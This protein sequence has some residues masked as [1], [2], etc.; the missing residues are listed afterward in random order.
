MATYSWDAVG[1]R[2]VQYF[3]RVLGL[4]ADGSASRIDDRVQADEPSSLLRMAADE[5]RNTA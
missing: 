4:G 3:D 5:S 1:I 2:L